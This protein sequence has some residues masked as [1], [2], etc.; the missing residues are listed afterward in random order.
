MSFKTYFIENQPSRDNH[1]L[2]FKCFVIIA[3]FFFVKYAEADTKSNCLM[4]HPH[5]DGHWKDKIWLLTDISKINLDLFFFL[6]C[7][8]GDIIDEKGAQYAWSWS[9]FIRWTRFFLWYFRI[10][11]KIGLSVN[12]NCLVLVCYSGRVYFTIIVIIELSGHLE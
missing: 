12:R 7:G 1:R 3:I 5:A 9:L 2:I 4:N 10:S 11:W 6:V 8:V